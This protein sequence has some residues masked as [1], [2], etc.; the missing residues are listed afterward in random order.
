MY[1]AYYNDLIQKGIDRTTA[2]LAAKQLAGQTLTAFQQLGET[3]ADAIAPSVASKVTQF[4]AGYKAIQ[5]LLG[6]PNK[7]NHIFEAGGQ[8]GLR[9]GHNLDDLVQKLGSREATV[10]EAVKELMETNLPAAGRFPD[11][12][13]D[14]AG[15]SVIIRGT[16]DQGFPK[17]SGIWTR[18]LIGKTYGAIQIQYS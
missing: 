3:C 10:K 13:V 6:N 4:A 8:L 11:T 14:I 7:L 17:I 5:H 16:V 18:E 1:N 15:T 9:T 2:S 12:T